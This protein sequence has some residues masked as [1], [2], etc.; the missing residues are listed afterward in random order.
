[1]RFKRTYSK[2][3]MGKHLSDAS[4]IKNGLK[5]GD[6]LSPLLFNFALEYAIMKVQENEEELEMNLLCETITIK[7]TQKVCWMPARN[8]SARTCREN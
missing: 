2:A 4:P 6:D 3:D 8:L 7:R 1:M 5:H